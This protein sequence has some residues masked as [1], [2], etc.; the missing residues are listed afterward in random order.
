[1][2]LGW[3]LIPALGGYW[4]LTHCNW[5]R[6]NA[7]RASGY[8]LFFQAAIAGAVLVVVA[9]VVTWI[10]FYLCPTGGELWNSFVPFAYSGT[11][12]LSA[13]LGL[14]LPPILNCFH[15]KEEATRQAA[16]D[17]GDLIEL[18]LA[19]STERQVFVEL[20][21]RSGKSY[22]GLALNSGLQAHNESDIALIPLASGYRDPDS[23]ELEITTYYAA[24]IDEWLE[25][26][27][28]ENERPDQPQ[29]TEKRLENLE[30]FRIVIPM[31]EI[32]SARLFDLDVYERFQN[33]T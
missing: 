17:K 10:G 31:S 2:A 1:M 7:A 27:E 18:L 13:I 11:A 32:V 28:E 24:V 16:L 19:E 30:D 14:S 3:L 5:T 4:F 21:L 33:E 25:E 15:D 20:T 22:I 9:Y 29:E 12:V 23:Q 26:L 8:H 6:F